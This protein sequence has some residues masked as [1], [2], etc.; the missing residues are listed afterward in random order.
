MSMKTSSYSLLFLLFLVFSFSAKAQ[1]SASQTAPNPNQNLLIGNWYE[2]PKES[3]GDTIVFRKTKYTLQQADNPAF[4]FSELNFID[5]LS[6]RINYWRWCYVNS[7]YEGTWSSA[8]NT[9]INLDFGPNKCK[10]ELKIIELSSSVL[11]IIIKEF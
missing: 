6:F 1:L 8:S 10:N 4:A 9:N 2:S 3:I 11:K 7:S 5:G